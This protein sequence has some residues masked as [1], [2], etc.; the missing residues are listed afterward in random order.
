MCTISTVDSY[1]SIMHLCYRY[2]PS[3]DIHGDT[4][5]EQDRI[6]F[7]KSV[8]EFMVR[9]INI[10]MYEK[11]FFQENNFYEYS[12][13]AYYPEVAFAGIKSIL[14]MYCC[15]TRK[16]HPRTRIIS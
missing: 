14:R 16:S 3:A 2:D 9:K 13:R 7:I 5:T 1:L 8:A 4:D 6:I 11:I 10:M 15:G 12:L